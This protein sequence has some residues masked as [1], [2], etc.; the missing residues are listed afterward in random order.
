MRKEKIELQKHL[1]EQGITG[2][3]SPATPASGVVEMSKDGEVVC[4]EGERGRV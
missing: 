4:V 1:K 3:P 2:V